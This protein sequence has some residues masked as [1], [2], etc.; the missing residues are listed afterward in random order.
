[1]IEVA[2]RAFHIE[3][4][5]S[6][7]APAS[8]SRCRPRRRR[9]RS[10][11][12]GRRHGALSRQGGRPRRYRFFEPDMDRAPARRNLELD[13]RRPRTANSSCTTSRS[14][15]SHRP[16]QRLRGAAALAPS[17]TRN[18]P[19]PSSFRSPR[20][21]AS[22]S[23]SANGCCSEAC[24]EAANWPADIK[25]AVN[26]RRCSSGAATSGRDQ[27]AGAPGCRRRGSNSRSPNPSS[28]PRAK[29]TSRRCTAR[30]LGVRISMD[31][32][33]T[34]YSSLSY[35]RS[36]PFDKIK[37]DRRSCNDSRARRIAWRSSGRSPAWSEPRHPHDGRRRRD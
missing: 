34:G 37:I 6:S 32:F 36:F 19:P 5:R 14:S 28:S 7:S 10:A 13:L 29:P 15:I 23:R 33:G 9:A 1:M 20:R 18:V 25:V 30:A 11:A 35:L 22:S 12:A 26:L 24:A 16:D 27:R 21:S 8:A 4:S 2:E 31:D 17:A 3:A